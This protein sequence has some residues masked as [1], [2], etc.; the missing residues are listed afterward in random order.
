MK[1]IIFLSIFSALSLKSQEIQGEDFKYGFLALA[2]PSSGTSIMGHAFLVF[3]KEKKNL[4]SSVAYQFNVEGG[5]D[6]ENEFKKESSWL[7]NPVKKVGE[8]RKM[9]TS[10]LGSEKRFFVS[11]HNALSLIRIYNLEKRPVLLYRLS[12]SEQ[13]VY[14][15]YQKTQQDFIERSTVEHFDYNFL[16]KNCLTMNLENINKVVDEHLQIDGFF[17][18]KWYEL[19]YLLDWGAYLRVAPL[20]MT[21]YLD[22]YPLTS[23]EEPIVWMPITFDLVHINASLEKYVDNLHFICNWEESN[24]QYVK[25]IVKRAEFRAKRPFLNFLKKMYDSCE[26][27]GQE[28]KRLYSMLIEDIYFQT[29]FPKDKLVVR[30]FLPVEI[31]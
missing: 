18:G 17:Q 2:G 23:D 3:S 14:E 26:A 20:L 31:F 21:A 8:L 7:R 6:K 24:A 15:L 5:E 11:R 25:K 13:Q 28:K 4:I 12:L 16:S 30:E 10:F 19:K 22:K 1:F 9:V 27:T 29:F